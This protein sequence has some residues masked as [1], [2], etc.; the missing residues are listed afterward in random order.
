MT[1]RAYVTYF[2]GRYVARAVAMLKSLRRRDPAAE[3]FALCF[4]DLAARLVRRLG[5]NAVT[6]VSPKALQAFEPRLA[7]CQDRDRAAFYATHKPILPLYVFDQRPDLGSI[8]HIDADMLFFA[9][10]GP[11]FAE[12]GDASVAVSP[13][14]YS[15]SY[16]RHI[17]HGRFNAGLIYWR[18]DRV[19][20]QCLGD[21]REDCLTWCEKKVMPDGRFMNQGY[22]TVWPDRYPG[23][24]VITHPGV[25][26]AIWNLASQPIRRARRVTIGGKPLILFHGTMVDVD[27]NGLWRVLLRNPE[28]HRDLPIAIDAIY[29]PYV[30]KVER[31]SRRLGL[32]PMMPDAEPTE[33]QRKPRFDRWTLIA[34]GRWPRSPKAW[35]VRALWSIGG[36]AGR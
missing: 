34:P 11:M 14:R 19:G 22:L 1:P 7:A 24:H 6:I 15:K 8:T 3:V 32:R 5:D 31:A 33:R 18:N 17:H 35:F 16:R 36:A 4:D 29:R 9:A 10:P 25:N 30:R 21:Y 2:D 20:R 27:A 12:I 23:V 13:H 28:A 26:V